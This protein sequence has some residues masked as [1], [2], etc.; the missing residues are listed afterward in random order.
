MHR[1]M[2]KN[3]IAAPVITLKM[4]EQNGHRRVEREQNDVQ[5]VI[6]FI[7]HAAKRKCAL[8]RSA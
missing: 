1:N 8:H 4:A 5:R 7:L 6:D 2:K 3:T